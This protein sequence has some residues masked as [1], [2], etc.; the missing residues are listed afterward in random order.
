MVSTPS[1]L[2]LEPK[3]CMSTDLTDLDLS[4]MVS[5]PTSRR[6]MELVSILYFESRL[7]VTV[8]AKE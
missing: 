2:E 5:V 3:S 4:S 7:A 6:P 1:M 8:R